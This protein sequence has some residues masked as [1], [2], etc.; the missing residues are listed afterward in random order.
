MDDLTRELHG[1][2]QWPWWEQCR[3]PLPRD[4]DEAYQRVVQMREERRLA[5]AIRDY[6]LAAERSRRPGQASG[7]GV[8]ST[9]T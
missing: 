3:D 9:R 8:S 2:D 5:R 1:H 4:D 6:A 7:G